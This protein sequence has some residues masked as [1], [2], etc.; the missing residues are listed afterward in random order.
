M[1]RGEN[2]IKL[3][4]YIL[5]I[6]LFV[7]CGIVYANDPPVG[8]I[9]SLDLSASFVLYDN[10]AKQITAI[11]VKYVDDEIVIDKFPEDSVWMYYKLSQSTPEDGFLL[12]KIVREYKYPVKTNVK[13]K[14]NIIYNDGF[15]NKQGFV[16]TKWIKRING[17]NTGQR[18]SL[19]QFKNFVEK[20]ASEGI[21]TFLDFYWTKSLDAH[22]NHDDLRE[23]FALNDY[24]SPDTKLYSCRLIHH[25]PFNG[26]RYI[27]VQ[28]PI[29][30]QNNNLENIYIEVVE[31]RGRGF[32]VRKRY[33]LKES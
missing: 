29:A 8:S 32:V 5:Y 23:Y 7:W 1:D 25:L 26:S 10:P 18:H 17:K 27:P 14:I 3:L 31:I 16:S 21:K 15:Y 13:G 33:W 6:G 12:I 2:N 20:K 24:S 30:D 4:K 19:I 22:I 11:G 9:P 28:V